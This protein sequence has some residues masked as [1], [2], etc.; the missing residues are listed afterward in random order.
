MMRSAGNASFLTTR[1]TSPTRRSF[2]AISCQRPSRHARVG[3][4]LSSASLRWRWMSSTMSLTIVTPSTMT[5]GP[6]VVKRPVGDSP[7]MSCRKEM[8]RK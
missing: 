1:H 5:S 7:G 6:S 3:R 4:P 8:S 2:H